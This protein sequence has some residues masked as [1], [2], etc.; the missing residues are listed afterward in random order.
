MFRN[1][2]DKI[3]QLDMLCIQKH[4]LRLLDVENLGRYL[5]HGSKHGFAMHL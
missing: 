4:K 1:Y 5:W 2:V 3:S